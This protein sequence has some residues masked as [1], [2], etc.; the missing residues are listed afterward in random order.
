LNYASA[1]GLQP[2]YSAAVPVE[3][4]VDFYGSKMKTADV[5]VQSSFDGIGTTHVTIPR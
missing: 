4:V 3:N 2:S 5:A 1:I